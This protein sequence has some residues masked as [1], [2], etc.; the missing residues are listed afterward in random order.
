MPDP[1]TPTTTETAALLGRSRR[2]HLVGVAAAAMRGLAALLIADGR[3]VSGSD[4]GSPA[5]LALLADHGVRAVHGHRTE[6]VDGADLLVASAAV[7]ADNP[8]LVIARERGIPILSHAQALGALMAQKDGIAVA[9]THGKSTTTAL[10][11]HILMTAGLDPT[12]AGG[13]EAIDFGGYARLGQGPHL[14]AEADEYGRRFLEL[15]PRLALITAAEPD[16]LDYYGSYE[17]VLEAFQQFVAGMTGDGIVVTCEDEPNLARLRLAR[18]RVRYGWAGHA[19]WRLERY[20]PQRDGRAQVTVRRPDGSRGIY[21]MQLH[22]RHNAANAI[23]ALALAT[24]A[25]VPEEAQ[26]AGLASYRGTRRRFE[27]LARQDG[28]WIVDDYA[29]HPTAVAANLNA[30]R[31]VHEGRLVAVF[32]PHTT[33]RTKALLPEFAQAFAA[34]DRVI[35]A[36]IYQPAGRT[37]G[38]PETTSHDLAAVMDHPDVVACHS[39]DEAHAHADAELQPDTLVIVLG[40]GDITHLARKLAAAVSDGQAKTAASRTVTTVPQLP[41]S[42]PPQ[43]S[44]AR[45]SL[46]ASP[47]AGAPSQHLKTA[48]PEVLRRHTSLK[49]GGPA[50]HF[51]SSD[52]VT[53][54][55]PLLG[56]AQCDGLA[57]L[58]LGGGSN[59]LVSDEGFDGVVLKY[60]AGEHR[61]EERADG[62][63]VVHAEAGTNFSNLAR[64]LARDGLSG[65]E[66]AA[67][68]PGTVGGAVV[69]NAGAFGGCV[70]DN[71]ADADLVGADGKSWTVNQ[72]ELDYAYRTSR[73]KRGEYGPTIV[74]AARFVVTRDDPRAAL[75]RIHEQQARRTASQP[76][77]LSAGSIFANPPGDF[78]GR[79]IE[80]AGLKGAR[81]GG[82]EISAQHANFIVNSGSATAQDVLRLM[83]QA[84][85]A[86]WQQFGV[87]LHPEVQLVG[88]WDPAELRA[89]T[90]PPE[91]ASAS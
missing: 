76:R 72:Q 50:R 70:A 69:N 84:Q 49:V 5:E 28:V 14:V 56:A 33:H 46:P 12:L 3:T 89:L 51:L 29:H 75:A 32:Q 47:P 40:A 55:A 6:N 27:T 53:V 15:H 41:A 61:V 20:A 48:G 17:A 7:P 63:L 73:L 23:G 42:S 31:D 71:L 37:D 80:A 45:A 13:A 82:A 22:G 25:G 38:Q 2:P 1:A 60:T 65:L 8:E 19:D 83:R 88:A 85:I 26:R 52:D 10:V 18:G 86:V 87:W 66:W 78:A 81:S 4:N 74:Q 68:V 9:G 54:L 77:Q 36:P 79:L 62:T 43:A 59:L 16:H 21:E 67:T 44:S 35:L 24:L 90:V 57:V 30:A 91:G 34:A 58:V 39:L 11:A 64:R